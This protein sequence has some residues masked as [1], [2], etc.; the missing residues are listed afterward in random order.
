MQTAGTAAVVISNWCA[1][2]SGRPALG[3]VSSLGQPPKDD[4]TT[5]LN[6][7][8]AVLG[9]CEPLALQSGDP[10]QPGQ[11]RPSVSSWPPGSPS[12]VA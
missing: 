11:A 3:P 9:K 1:V 5:G 6:Q 2:L 4:T 8:L 12:R 10:T 7:N